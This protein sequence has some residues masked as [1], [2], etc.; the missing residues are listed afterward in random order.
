MT[1]TKA[2]PYLHG[3]SEEEQNRLRKQAHFG[4]YT[5]YQDINLSNVTDLLEVGCGVGAQSEIILR[6]FPDLTLTGI[7]RS[8]KQLAVAQHNLAKTPYAVGRFDLREMDAT[9]M[10]FDAN[11]F[12]G[13]FLCWIL[14]HVPDPIRVLSEVRRVLRPG[15][16]V[17]ITEVM[18][19]SFF[20]DPYSPNVWKYW[21]AFN[22]Y[23]LKQKGDPFV[24]AKLGNFL[25]SL[26]YNDIRTEIK[27]WFLDNRYPQARKEC[28]EYWADLLLS[29]SEQ[30]VAANYVSAEVVEGMKEEMA[31]VAN[32][33]NAVFFYSFV[34]ARAR[35]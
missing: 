2:F 16:L 35:T 17:Y 6:R 5:V 21:M 13:A 11:S 33:P 19:S 27:T 32:D 15:S 30:L 7:D 23:Q 29:A 20:L 31:K 4:E 1:E 10:E 26:G 12:D 8:T 25:M 28:V 14:E 18:N 34:Q 24:G 9:A 22:D 3:F